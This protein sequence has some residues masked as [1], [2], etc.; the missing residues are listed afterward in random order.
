MPCRPAG[1][2]VRQWVDLKETPRHCQTGDVTMEGV[3]FA[4][5][6]NF[7]LTEACLVGRKYRGVGMLGAWPREPPRLDLGTLPKSTRFQG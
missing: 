6:A 2:D 5:T 7:P 3:R 1:R 4:Y